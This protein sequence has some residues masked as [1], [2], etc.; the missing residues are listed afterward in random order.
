M[1]T[2]QPKVVPLLYRTTRLLPLNIVAR[3]VVRI[4]NLFRPRDR[5]IPFFGEFFFLNDGA[6]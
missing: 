5:G 1:K 6:P 2:F 4:T 3:V